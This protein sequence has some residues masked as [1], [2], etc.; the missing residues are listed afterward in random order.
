MN[1]LLLVPLPIVLF[2]ASCGGG[3]GDLPEI[4]SF[5]VDRTAIAAGETVKLSWETKNGKSVSISS[6]P[7]EAVA[8]SG[9]MASGE[10]TTGAIAV[11]TTFK[12]TVTS[13]SRETVEKTVSVTTS[14]VGIL[15]F[16]AMPAAIQRGAEVALSY[17][18]AGTA[19]STKITAGD[20]EIYGGGP[21]LMG[22]VMHAPETTTTYTLTVVAASGSITETAMV[23]VM[24]VLPVI[25]SLQVTPSI[26]GEPFVVAWRTTNAMEIQISLDGVVKKPWTTASVAVGTAQLTSTAETN[27]V[28][29][30]ARNIDGMVFEDKVV[31]SLQRPVFTDFSLTP[32]SYNG[33]S[34][35]ATVTWATEF[36][37]SLELRING[38]VDIGFPTTMLAG[39][40]NFRASGGDTRV[41]LTAI[42]PAA[43]TPR[44]GV[45]AEGYIEPEPNDVPMQAI[46][47]DGDGIGYRGTLDADDI[48]LYSVVVPEGGRIYAIAGVTPNGMCTGDTAIRLFA[49]DGVTELGYVDDVAFPQIAPCAEMN[50][51]AAAYADTLAAGTYYIAIEGGALH[52]MAEPYRLIVRV[53]GPNPPLPGITYTEIGDPLWK[54]ADCQLTSLLMADAN[55]FDPFFAA[56]TTLVRPLHD[57]DVVGANELVPDAA[58]TRPYDEEIAAMMGAHG[59]VSKTQFTEEEF[60][61]P[62]GVMLLCS[63]LPIATATTGASYDSPDGL[64]IPY[65]LMPIVDQVSRQKDQMPFSADYEA[66]FSSYVDLAVSP[67]GAGASH[68]ILWDGL[69]SEFA[70]PPGPV[71]GS[72]RWR[73]TLTDT[74]GE[75]WRVDVNFEVQ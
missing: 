42:N 75:G 64:I 62:N 23:E 11:N 29:F 14:G 4:V 2:A 20:V 7:I 27:T 19:Q 74:T 33:T 6:T 73:H 45:V 47:L 37:T 52:M 15:S 16:T 61:T 70:D 53:S 3:D 56:L 50:P 34:V 9:L 35:E 8:L 49:P 46:P 38:T 69:T 57:F 44:E 43:Q 18:L 32:E 22:S 68:R 59:F 40:Y 41:T 12:L 30:E 31:T 24:P 10:Y 39:S 13:E 51:K 60:T 36:T 67:L 5:N 25:D 58:H 66:R 63:I 54:V 48:D 1:R 17:T 55:G 65:G 28:R 26:I 72:Y 21:E 71:P